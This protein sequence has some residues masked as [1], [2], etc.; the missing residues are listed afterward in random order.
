LQGLAH[1]QIKSMVFPVGDDNIERGWTPFFSY[2]FLIANVVIFLFQASMPEGVLAGF[3]TEYGTVPAE[4]SR[5][6]DLQTLFTSI[7]LHGSWMHL[8]GNM[9]YLWIFADNIEAVVGNIRFVLFYLLGG[10]VAGLAQVIIEPDSMT[11]CIGAS[12]AIAAVMG[13]YI[14][15][16]PHSRVKML[17]LIFFTIFYIPAWV[18]LGFWFVQQ[19]MSGMNA[20]GMT[21]EDAGGVAWW[22]HI[23]GFVFGL[24]AGLLF[25]RRASDFILKQL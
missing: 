11:P 9:L 8:I 22:A 24:L 13:A 21:G 15:M 17:F 20:L 3:V 6:I 18:F 14:V 2:L 23:G 5:G 19:A 25:R 12:G 4:I 7:F 16:F 10:L 1:H